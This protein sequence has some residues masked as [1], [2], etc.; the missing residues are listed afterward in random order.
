MSRPISAD[1]RG[2]KRESRMADGETP[3][4]QN[5]WPLRGDMSTS[6]LEG[7]RESA[8]GGLLQGS[9]GHFKVAAPNPGCWANRIE[10][11][12]PEGSPCPI[13]PRPPPGFFLWTAAFKT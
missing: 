10:S 3:R 7:P 4:H 6:R 5:R 12:P 11:E 1:P 9:A 13:L 8:P 2:G